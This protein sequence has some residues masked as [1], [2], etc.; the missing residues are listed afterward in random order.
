VRGRPA[1]DAPVADEGF[2][3]LGIDELGL[4]ET[5]RRILGLLH[6]SGQGALGLKTIGA[7]IG[8]SEDTI[9]E[10]YEPH[11]LRLEFLRKT[12]RGRELTEQ[13]RRWCLK[14]GDATRGSARDS[15]ERDRGA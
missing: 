5:D 6:R 12:S 3:R 9:E 10:V 8:E 14:R 11:L 4:E 1:V 7:G 13:G 2:T 15:K